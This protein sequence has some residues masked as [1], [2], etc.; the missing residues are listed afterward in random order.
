MQFFGAKITESAQIPAKV[1]EFSDSHNQNLI[2]EL[3][4]LHFC[5]NITQ[6]MSF[7]EKRCIFALI[8][9]YIVAPPLQKAGDHR[10]V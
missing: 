1:Q 3:K 9:P 10:P 2:L 7:E 5:S 4:K 6:L 8:S